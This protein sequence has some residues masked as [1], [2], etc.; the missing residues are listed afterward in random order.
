MGTN[1]TMN[2]K[3]SIEHYVSEND[4]TRGA[5]A[6][7]IGIS[8]SSLYEKMDGK[9]PW[10]LDEIIRLASVMGCEE[11]ELWADRKPAT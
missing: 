5:L 9:R 1:V 6:S 7:R 3:Q 10:L 11:K 4:L 8:R 2:I